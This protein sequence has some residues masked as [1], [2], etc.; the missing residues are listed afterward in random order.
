VWR[1]AVAGFNAIGLPEVA[2][3]VVEAGKRLGG[4]PSMNRSERQA[5]LASQSQNFD[6]LDRRLYELGAKLKPEA[7]ITKYVR[8]N[9]SAFIFIGIVER[10]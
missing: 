1:D 2:E 5:M 10:P 6:D 4:T 3:V 8:S 7:P 9:P